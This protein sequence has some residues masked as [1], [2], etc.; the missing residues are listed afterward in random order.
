MTKQTEFILQTYVED[1]ITMQLDT[2]NLDET[3]EEI[4]IEE[5]VDQLTESQLRELI[6][7]GTKHF[8]IHDYTVK[9]IVKKAIDNFDPYGIGPHSH[10]PY[11]EYEPEIEDIAER[12][13]FGMSADDIR[14]IIEAIFIYYFDASF[15]SESYERPAYEI[16]RHLDDVI[17]ATAKTDMEKEK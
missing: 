13:T 2:G 4:T 9:G 8:T 14:R 17:I 1:T 6:I 5:I 11:D 15:P 10:G 16:Y 3:L 7:Q 12:L